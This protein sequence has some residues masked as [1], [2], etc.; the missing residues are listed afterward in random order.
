MNNSVKEQKLTVSEVA[1]E[2][3][4]ISCANLTEAS[5][6]SYNSRL[7]VRILPIIGSADISTVRQPHIQALLNDLAAKG[8]SLKTQKDTVGVL[9]KLF[10]YALINDYVS[11]NPVS[12]IVLK[13]TPE[14]KY[15]IYSEE[16]FRALVNFYRDSIDV[17]PIL[18]A[19]RC[20]LRLSEILGLQWK[21]IKAKEKLIIISGAAVTVGADVVLSATNKSSAGT[22]T[23][24]VPEEVITTLIQHRIKGSTY[25]YP[26][27][28]DITQP[29]NGK[30]FGNK[31][32][33]MLK[34]AGLPHTRFHDLRHFA[35]TEFLDAGVPDKYAAAYLGHSDT[36]MTKKYQH[37]RKNV[38]PYPLE[39][40]RKKQ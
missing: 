21:N 37:I 9:H 40:Q 29:E 6:Y 31:F 10:E 24:Q 14:Y 27:H 26:S 2:W 15:N 25:V 19:G 5:K 32:R 23:L 39:M 38:I 22:R 35:A 28:V 17:I 20:G 11:K 34:K 7:Q 33:R 3:I 13:K 4:S 18:L 8:R 12:H 30:Y 16:Q 36:N 1:S